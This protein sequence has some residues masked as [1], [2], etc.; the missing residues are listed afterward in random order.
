[1]EISNL[2]DTFFAQRTDIVIKQLS[3]AG[4][5]ATLLPPDITVAG[6]TNT[7]DTFQLTD[8]AD[9]SI[10]N[11]SEDGTVYYTLDGSDP[12]ANNG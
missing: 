9:I 8:N 7:V 3:D 2:R 1:M 10:A 6:K 12:R 4:L 5:F 11:A